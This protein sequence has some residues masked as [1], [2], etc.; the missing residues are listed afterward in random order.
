VRELAFVGQRRV[1]GAATRVMAQA[2][3]PCAAHFGEVEIETPRD[4][5]RL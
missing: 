1:E 3:K 4:R 5:K 2:A